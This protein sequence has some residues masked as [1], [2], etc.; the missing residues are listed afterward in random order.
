MS[1]F[2]TLSKLPLPMGVEKPNRTLE[3]YKKIDLLDDFAR[4]KGGF[5]ED[6]RD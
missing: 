3:D 2:Q 6:H 5:D 1:Y 4:G